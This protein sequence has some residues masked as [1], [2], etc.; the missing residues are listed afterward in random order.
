MQVRTN[1]KAGGHQ[2]NH[3]QILIHTSCVRVK[4]GHKAG[5]SSLNHSQSL[6]NSKPLRVKTNVK[7]GILSFNHGIG[8][9]ANHNQTVVRDRN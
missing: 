9:P 4:S 7:A 5:G 8:Q 6:I 2:S 3:N 1:V